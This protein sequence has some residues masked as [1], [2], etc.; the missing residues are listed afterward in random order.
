MSHNFILIFFLPLILLRPSLPSSLPPFLFPTLFPFSSSSKWMR[1][2]SL[3]RTNRSASENTLSTRGVRK[4]SSLRRP[5]LKKK[6]HES[7]DSVGNEPTSSSGGGG[8]GGGGKVLG[9]I[10]SLLHRGARSL[11]IPNKR[12]GVVQRESGGIQWDSVSSISSISEISEGRTTGT[13]EM[14]ERETIASV[15]PV[16]LYDSPV[17]SVGSMESPTPEMLLNGSGVGSSGVPHPDTQPNSLDS[18]VI[19]DPL[20]GSWAGSLGKLG[21]SENVM[22]QYI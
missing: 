2:N 10:G 11:H 21:R 1:L 20:S 13:D 22:V 8:G 9:E 17:F 6:Q 15:S 3:K 14:S 19:S 18:G 12:R 7:T 16:P 4:S 5:P